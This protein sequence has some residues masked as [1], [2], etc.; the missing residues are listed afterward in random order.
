MKGLSSF[1]NLKMMYKITIISILGVVFF[2]AGTLF[3]ILPKMERVMMVEKQIALKNMVETAVSILD[4]YASLEAAGKMDKTAAQSASLKEI[5]Q[6]RYAGKNYFFITD[7]EPKMILHPIESKLNGSDLSDF[8]DPT[9]K[10]LFV[11]CAEVSKKK[12]GGYVNYLWPK[13]GNDKPVSK[14]TYVQL[15]PAW[16]WVVGT[17]I[18]IDD[19]ANRMS[20][21]RIDLVIFSSLIGMVVIVIAFFLSRNIAVQLT[22]AVDLAK[23][24]ADGNLSR[25]IDIVQKDEIGILAKALNGMIV[26]LREMFG[27]ISGGVQTLTS[28]STELSAVSS[29]MAAGSEQSS[30]KAKSVSTATEEM[31][32][33]MHAIAS[34]LDQTSS[35]VQIV[36][37]AAEQMTATISEITVNAEKGGRISGEAMDQAV[38]TSTQ[39]DELGKAVE[40]IGRV[41]EAIAEISEQTNLLALNA[42]IEAARAGEAGKGFA[43]V[44]NEIKELAKQ[45]ADAT[46]EIGSRISNI[47]VKTRDTVGTIDQIS[48]VIHDLHDIVLSVASAMEQQSVAT[49]EIT[50][51]VNQAARGVEDV[52]KNVVQTTN[53]SGTIAK[54]MEEVYRASQ[55][56]AVGST[57]VKDSAR[58]LSRLAAQLNHM[59]SGFTLAES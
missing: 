6:L 56:A 27:N 15:F 30:K 18:Y 40:Q 48:K 26:N 38:L 14:L 42:T 25:T 21:L 31:N 36:A 32:G 52:N 58:E 39:V 57:Q 54:D 22:K 16:G 12:G 3:Y 55:E 47:Q 23:S 50:S 46:R 28:S 49:K 20:A 7:L 59:M 17:G 8:K 13:P 33:N 11:A 44:S 10:K 43:V 9:G 4:G 53:V 24:V 19:V 29:Q 2:L 34:A 45:T 35:S 1:N 5:G 41:T 37:A 51:N